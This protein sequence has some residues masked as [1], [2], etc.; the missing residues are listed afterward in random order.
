MAT[1]AK[2]KKKKKDII[3]ELPLDNKDVENEENTDKM[4]VVVKSADDSNIIDNVSQETVKDEEIKI[5]N[6]VN[7]NDDPQK[8]R[9]DGMYEKKDQEKDT[10]SQSSS[11][12][13]L[14]SQKER[15][16]PSPFR[17]NVVEPAP[18]DGTSNMGSAVSLRSNISA[19]EAWSVKSEDLSISAK[20]KRPKSS[21]STSTV[22]SRFDSNKNKNR[23]DTVS[24]KSRTSIEN[25]QHQNAYIPYLYARNCI[26]QITTDMECMKISH[27]RIVHDIENNYR[28]IEDETQSQFNMFVLCLKKEYVEKVTTFKQVIDVHR[29]ELESKETYW[30]DVF[31]SLTERNNKILKDKKVLLLKHKMEI[32]RLIKEKE[33]MKTDLI[34]TVDKAYASTSQVEKDCT[35]KMEKETTTYKSLLD[36]LEE[37]K[38][39]LNKELEKEKNETERLNALLSEKAI[40]VV[41]VDS[42]TVESTKLQGDTKSEKQTSVVAVALGKEEQQR[43]EDE[44]QLISKERTD[45]LEE[46][47]KM[48]KERQ[49]FSD[50]RKTYMEEK[51]NLQEQIT[52]HKKL[53]AE[54]EIKY[55]SLKTSLEDSLTIQAKYK[56]LE[57]QY[58]VLSAIVASNTESSKQAAKDNEVKTKFEKDMMDSEKKRLE[59]EITE[60]E[61]KFQEKH[62]RPPE[63]G[64]K[65][66]ST[67]ELYTSLGEVDSM[68]EDL[69]LKIETLQKVQSG[70]VPGPPEVSPV[71]LVIKEPQVKTIEVMVPDP[72]TVEALK[73]CQEELE[74]LQDQITALQQDKTYLNTKLS[75][76][77]T[78]LLSSKTKIIELETELALCKDKP[79]SVVAPSEPDVSVEEKEKLK[80]TIE[81]KNEELERLRQENHDMLRD[82]KKMMKRYNKLEEKLKESASH[83]INARLLRVVAA[84]VKDIHRDVPTA[85]EKVNERLSTVSADKNL[86]DE[87]KDLEIQALNI[88]QTG[89]IDTN[90]LVTSDVKEDKEIE[91]NER[92]I[93]LESE[94]EGLKKEKEGNFEKILELEKEIS[95]MKNQA[96]QTIPIP[97][98]S[99]EGG[100]LTADLL[101]ERTAHD[102]TKTELEALQKQL[103]N[104]KEE[105][106]N[107]KIDL[108]TH[109]NS[110][111]NTLNAEIKAKEEEIIK[112]KKRNETLEKDRLANVPIDSAKEIKSLQ[113]KIAT[114]EKEKMELDSVKVT[115]NSKIGELQTKLDQAIKNLNAQKTSNKDLET[116]I[117]EVR[118]EKEKAVKE[119]TAQLEKKE[120][121]T[122]ERT[123]SFVGKAPPDAA[124]KALKEQLMTT[125]RENTELNNRIKQLEKEISKSSK[126]DVDT[127]AIDKQTKRHEKILKELE[128]KYEMEKSKNE[129]N[130]EN[131]KEKEEEVKSLTKDCTMKNTEIQK[132]KNELDALGIAAKEGV[133]A[134]VKVKSLEADNK[135]LISE[136]K[137]L[138]ENFNT[139]RVLRKKYYN[140][141]EDMKGKIR[142][143]CRARPLS[144]SEKDRGN[145]SVI[146]SP[147]EYSLNITTSRGLKEFQFDQVFLENS[148]QERVFEDTNNLIQSA[149]DGY[150][151]CMFA[152]GQTGSGKTFTM[153]GD[154]EQNYPGIAPR[155]FQRIFELREENKSKFD[156]KVSV[157]MLELYNEK[158][159]D[160]FAK[161]GNYDE[162]RLDIKKDKKGMVFI[163]GAVVKD[164][165]ND[166]ELFALFEEGSKNR[167]TASTKMNAESS[168][169]HLVVGIVLESTNKITGQLMKGKLSLVDLAGS[170]RVGKTGATAE[171]LKEAM[172][173]NKSLSALGDVISALS[174]EQSFIPY[175]NNKL[176]M[177]MQDSLGGN[178]KTLMFVNISPADYN[179]DESVIS[180]TYASRVKLITNDASKNADNKEIVRLKDIIQKLKH[181][182]NVDED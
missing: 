99:T 151:V 132:L 34:A 49:M 45:C 6:D 135:H 147:D 5:V 159:I 79:M 173:I 83:E 33:Q 134:A 179:Q 92:I 131:I 181:G 182:E 141:V 74:S 58:A 73:K 114:L 96:P 24:L 117:K 71:P 155:A 136:N 142:V 172:S 32:D 11:V 67:K 59:D 103:L 95:D 152:Y 7:K 139:E 168:R 107:E 161:P 16:S 149:V 91:L 100:E 144:S 177:L 85:S 40:A 62:N 150:N 3:P 48:E 80:K 112:L 105:F 123:K 20:T 43:M 145:V 70:N 101:T 31:K 130:V 111:K 88:I 140:M 66:D 127:V 146:N 110:I 169:S 41:N 167:H 176:T 164:A 18:D 160:L 109:F 22:I 15:R 180:L 175:R 63:E 118:S 26:K 39:N 82:M 69:K 98:T 2:I 102:T 65:P 4:P 90:K 138:T 21:S 51:I 75:D 156:L 29:I 25:E 30:K 119:V 57:N 113:K 143:Y 116:K 9:K 170:E 76:V 72:S 158:L 115:S 81:D 126:S 174:S 36:K 1:K 23:D 37:E 44:R 42:D 171:Q 60:W 84:V 166:Q 13:S 148:S 10:R 35:E 87:K 157:Y 124:T 154:R 50:E 17:R 8:K 104:I 55:G 46:R 153:I 125:K 162:D 64:D 122:L 97:E 54:W 137:L 56:A 120:K 106:N 93:D 47:Q 68:V 128:K 19:K 108:E 89:V 14:S 121:A 78:D 129:R 77:N 12:L 178:A 163:Q 165:H 61:K 27:I 53:S 52:E 86:Y 28:A 94:N 38:M 133:E